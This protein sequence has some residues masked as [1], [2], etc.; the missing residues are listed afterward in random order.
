M[1][2]ALAIPAA[3]WRKAKTEEQRAALRE[4]YT[5]EMTPEEQAEFLAFQEQATA[6]L[7]TRAAEEAEEKA[8]QEIIRQEAKAKYD[9]MTPKEREKL[10]NKEKN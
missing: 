9:A 3:E 1:K 10:L 4:K 6:E 5:V 2:K 8:I 7:E